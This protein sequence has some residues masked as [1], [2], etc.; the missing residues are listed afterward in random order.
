MVGR[1]LALISPCGQSLSI[2]TF[3][4]LSCSLISNP[5]C[6]VY[7]YVFYVWGK[8]ANFNEFY[9]VNGFYVLQNEFRVKMLQFHIILRLQ[10]QKYD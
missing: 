8:F 7:V 3:F 5:L 1:C 6:S 9:N 10:L 4:I 2:S